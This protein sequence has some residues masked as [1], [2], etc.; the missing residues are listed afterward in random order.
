MRANNT[1][2]GWKR[3]QD[4]CEDYTASDVSTNVDPEFQIQY[5]KQ[6]MDVYC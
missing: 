4:A 1:N 2:F 3:H 5:P 6:R